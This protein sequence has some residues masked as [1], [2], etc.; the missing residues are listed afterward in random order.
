VD[1][2]RERGLPVGLL[3][4]RFLRPFPESELL[5]VIGR[6]R[7]VGVLE[8]AVSFGYQGA[9]FSDVAAALLESTPRPTL[10]N[11]VAGL[12]GRDISRDD[13]KAMFDKLRALPA[14]ARQNRLDFVGVQ[15][16]TDV[17]DG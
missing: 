15:D 6:P 14:G 4:L 2:L 1:E 10:Q 16:V 17:T 8:K 12:G 7:A 9:V 5:R 11:F 13:I 3:K